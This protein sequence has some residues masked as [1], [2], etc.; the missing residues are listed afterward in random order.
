[1]SP[2]IRVR[3][4]YNIFII[5]SQLITCRLMT[6]PNVNMALFINIKTHLLKKNH[7]KLIKNRESTS[8]SNNFW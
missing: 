4:F 2:T 3:I 6:F 8:C 7:W 5:F 1:M